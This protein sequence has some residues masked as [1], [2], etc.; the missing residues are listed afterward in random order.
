MR[1]NGMRAFFEIIDE[2]ILTKIMN[3]KKIFILHLLAIY[4]KSELLIIK[5]K[6]H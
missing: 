2:K 1:E 5:R 4:V 3:D 6:K